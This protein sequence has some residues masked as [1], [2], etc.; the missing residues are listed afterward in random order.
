MFLLATSGRG[1][2]GA[3]PLASTTT[4]K[5]ILVVSGRSQ[6]AAHTIVRTVIT[7]VRC[8]P[9]R[10]RAL[11]AVLLLGSG[12]LELLI[13]LLLLHLEGLLVLGVVI[14]F[15]Q[16]RFHV[17]VVTLKYMMIIIS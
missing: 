14:H 17:F 9:V 6:G 4:T 7:L 2:A 3:F 12:A 8:F 15:T 13:P 16:H 1:R 10:V 11:L 5:C